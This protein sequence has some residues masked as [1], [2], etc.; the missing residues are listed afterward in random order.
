[1]ATAPR[2]TPDATHCH[3]GIRVPVWST[4]ELVTLS[5][6][7]MMDSKEYPT[8]AFCFICGIC[9]SSGFRFLKFSIAIFTMAFAFSPAVFAL[10]RMYSASGICAIGLVVTNLVWKHLLKGPRAGKIHCTSTTMASQAPVSTT[11]SCCRKLP[12]IGTP[13]RIAT[14]L[15]VQ[16]TPA[17]L[18][19]FAPISFAYAIISGSS[20]YSQIIS[21][22]DGS[23]P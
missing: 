2:I 8:V 7:L 21:E 13:R 23:W 16:Q 5:R 20:A 11:F 12:A 10:K 22:S 19:P 15:E 4:W 18:I 17:T 1:M 3:S 6:V 14:S 9:T